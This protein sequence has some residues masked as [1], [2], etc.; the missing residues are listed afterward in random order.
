[1]NQDVERLG[2]LHEIE[3][4]QRCAKEV[5][6]RFAQDPKSY[7]SDLLSAKSIAEYY[8]LLFND[9][10][11]KGSFSYP[12][13]LP[14][15]KT[16]NLFDL[17]AENLQHI[18]RPEFKGTYFLNQ[19][20]KTAGKYFEVFDDNTTEIV[21]PYNAEAKEIIADLFSQK[22]A[23]ND[24]FLKACIEKAKPYTVQIFKYQN[25][26]LREYGMLSSDDEGHFTALNG[27]CYNAETGV[28]I[29]NFIY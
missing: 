23:F 3:A 22:A 4:A 20:F 17:L 25:R 6:H 2:M 26:K 5:L 19:A 21:V 9:E 13:K 8:Q 24:A 11:I 7:A 27:Q 15:N 29:E 18:E 28:T 12:Q 16:E 10:Y 14:Y 1:M